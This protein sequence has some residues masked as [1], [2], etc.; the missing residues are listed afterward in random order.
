MVKELND[1]MR[2]YRNNNGRLI[3]DVFI[4]LPSKRTHTDYYAAIKQPIDF[5]KIQQRLKSDD[6]ETFAQFDND[7]QLLFSNVQLFYPVGFNLFLFL[8]YYC[9]ALNTKIYLYKRKILLNLK[10]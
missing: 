3:C 9:F 6:Y 5:M 2:N 10:I 1:L 7:V 4:R 8:S